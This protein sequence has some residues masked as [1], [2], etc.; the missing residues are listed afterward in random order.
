MNEQSDIFS[1][2]GK[3]ALVTGASSGIGLHTAWTLAKAGATVVLAARREDKLAEA[4]QLMRAQGLCVYAVALDVTQP[5]SISDAWEKAERLIGNPIDILFNC[6]GIAYVERFLSQDADQVARVFDTN[7]KGVFL[8]AQ[9]GARRMAQLGAGS[10]INVASTSGLRAAGRLSSY[11]A[12]K[13]GLLHLTSIMALELAPKQIR[14]NALAPGNIETDMH[15]HFESAGLAEH[16][17]QRIP[18]RRFGQPRDLDGATLLL[19]SDAGRYITGA[20]IPV[21]GGQLLSWM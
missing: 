12:A 15:E 5:S 20:V 7:L 19:A 17:R 6:A 11:G 4:V 18:Q 14:V 1:L 3:A 2:E 13:A 16:I 10:I 9:E 21:D 8:M